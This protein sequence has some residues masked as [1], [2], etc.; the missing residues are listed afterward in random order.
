LDCQD[1][2][3]HPGYCYRIE[4]GKESNMQTERHEVPPIV[5]PKRRRPNTA[6]FAHAVIK[7]YPKVMAHLAE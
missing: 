2:K 6:K 7:K 1:V 5:K 3:I 4:H